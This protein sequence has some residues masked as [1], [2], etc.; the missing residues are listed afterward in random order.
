MALMN[1][2]QKRVRLIARIFAETGIKDLFLGVHATIRE[3]ATQARQARLSNQWVTVDPTTWAER[4][5]MTIE[6][7]LGASGK[8][9]ELAAMSQVAQVMQTI[10]QEQGG[11]TGPIV[12]PANVYAA[13]KRLFSKL[14]IKTPELFLTDPSNAPANAPP[15][16]KSDPDMHR[17]LLQ[18]QRE[19]ERNAGELALKKAQME[20]EF[21][22]KRYDIDQRTK[23]DLANAAS[24]ARSPAPLPQPHF[25]DV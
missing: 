12:Y 6:I 7:G 25:G 13:A 21:A 8:D 20:G 11:A 17:V 9:F 2:A 5:D 3:N 19:S 16:Q 15:A 1:S 4:N 23:V 24:R 10:V 22:L 14:G 18:H